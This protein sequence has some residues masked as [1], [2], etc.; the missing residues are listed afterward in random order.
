VLPSSLPLIF[1][2]LRL[3]LGV[4]W[5]VLIAAEM[6]AQNPGLGKF[7]WDEFQ[8]GSSSRSPDHGRRPDHRHHRL[9]ARPRDVRAA[10]GVHLFRH[11]LRRRTMAVPRTVRRKQVLRRGGSERTRCSPTSTL[12][13]EE[14]EFVAIVGFSGSGKTTLISAIAGLVAPDAGEVL[15]KGAPIDGPGP[16]R[17][18]VFQSY[19]LMPWLTVAGNVALAVDAVFAGRAGRSGARARRQYIA[20]SAS[21]MPPT[22]GRPSFPAAC[23]SAS[24][25]PARSP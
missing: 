6:L 3:S 10:V 23:A 24:P 4:G 9:P 17:G 18:V 16:D 1:T 21:T 11:A 20:W 13:V 8:N 12:S 22:G 14:G 2:G 25:S 19:S 5:M 15:F 7:V